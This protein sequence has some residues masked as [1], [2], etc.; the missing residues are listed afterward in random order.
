MPLT[1]W[2]KR[3]N[4]RTQRN[5]LFLLLSS[6]FF[7]F[8]EK[9]ISCRKIDGRYWWRHTRNRD[10]KKNKKK[11]I[12]KDEGEHE[13]ERYRSCCFSLLFYF[14]FLNNVY[15]TEILCCGYGWLFYFYSRRRQASALV[16]R[17]W[18]NQWRDSFLS[19]LLFLFSLFLFTDADVLLSIRQHK[20]RRRH[21]SMNIETL[22]F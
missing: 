12:E 8:S 22:F 19:F 17:F 21:A 13:I 2:K 6:P 14:I 1:P 9:K 4:C 7:L 18:M 10:S 16:W 20:D 15:T 3:Q 5:L 11:Y